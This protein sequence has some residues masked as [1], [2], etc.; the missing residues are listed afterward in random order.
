MLSSP[1]ENQLVPVNLFFLYISPLKSLNLA[2]IPGAKLDAHRGTWTGCLNICAQMGNLS[3]WKTVTQK[4]SHRVIVLAP[5]IHF[6]F[7]TDESNKK[8]LTETFY[9]KVSEFLIT[10][11]SVN[12]ITPHLYMSRSAIQRIDDFCADQSQSYYL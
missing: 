4:H 5:S 8:L 9:L 6:S 11:I 7:N 2:L 10:F 1:V 3:I 12:W